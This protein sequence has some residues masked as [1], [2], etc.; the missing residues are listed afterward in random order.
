LNSPAVILLLIVSM[1]AALFAADPVVLDAREPIPLFIADGAGTAGYASGD[2]ELCELALNAWSRESGGSLRFTRSDAESRAI[3]QV[4]WVSPAQ[5]RFGEMERIDVGGRKGARVNVV[6]DTR[7]QGEALAKAAAADGLL[8]DSI[9]YLT[10]V[11]ELGHALGL[12]H[13]AQYADI[14]YSFQHGGDIL[15]YFM[16]YRE[17]LQA[18]TDIAKFSG[19]SSAD[20]ATLKALYPLK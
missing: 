14:M 2:R 8:R 13:T 11:H 3:V 5:G 6:A 17:K 20:I 1:G 7:L 9:V 16:R 12:A 4:R 19:M 10:C 15:R 18:R